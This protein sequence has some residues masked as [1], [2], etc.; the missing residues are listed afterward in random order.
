[1]VRY[2][3]E[4]RDRFGVKPICRQLQIARSTYYEHKARQADP[5]RQPARAQRDI[6]LR[7][8]IRRVWHEN[9]C[10]YGVRKTWK[11]LNQ[12]WVADFTYVAT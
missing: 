5:S 2:I 9:F 4:H 8:E 11:Q 7:P 3:D 6:E 1:M 12:L 10:V